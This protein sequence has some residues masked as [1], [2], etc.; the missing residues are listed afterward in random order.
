MLTSLRRRM[1]T[2]STLSPE[3]VLILIDCRGAR[4]AVGRGAWKALGPARGAHDY[5]S[6]AAHRA[7]FSY[8]AW[9]RA[10]L[11][12]EQAWVPGLLR[13]AADCN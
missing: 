12:A 11:F 6:D 9:G 10:V 13:A 2:E 8:R 3:R 7:A 1:M 5:A 4:A